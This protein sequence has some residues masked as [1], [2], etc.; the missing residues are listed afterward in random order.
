MHDTLNND[1]RL[2][3]MVT[4]LEEYTRQALAM[5]VRT[6]MTAGEVLEVLYGLFLRPGKPDH[7]LSDIGRS[8]SMRSSLSGSSVP[9]PS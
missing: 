4:A 6:T 5:A 9:V 8:S 1:R 7:L 2:Y 3:K